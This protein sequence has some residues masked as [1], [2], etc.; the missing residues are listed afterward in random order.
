VRK[1]G[2]RKRGK[3]GGSACV[4][5]FLSA[6]PAPAEKKGK[7][8]KRKH[9]EGKGGKAGAGQRSL[10]NLYLSSAWRGGNGLWGGG[11][12]ERSPYH[13]LFSLYYS[14]SAGRKPRTGRNLGGE[15]R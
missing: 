13:R 3:E 11:R 2:P 7:K 12:E 15:F 1:K 5:R 6:S 4:V 8:R 14:L 10:F 9:E